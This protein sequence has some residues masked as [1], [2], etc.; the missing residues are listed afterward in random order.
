[1]SNAR[2]HKPFKEEERL[3]S[4]MAD[5]LGAFFT[6]TTPRQ[7]PAAE[8]SKEVVQQL[9]QEQVA[10]VKEQLQEQVKEQLQQIQATTPAVHVAAAKKLPKKLS[11]LVNKEG[12]YFSDQISEWLDREWKKQPRKQQKSKSWIVEQILRQHWGLP[13]LEE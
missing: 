2:S 9:L 5:G 6:N 13:P 12:L 10:Q 7:P 8:M 4:G 11:V 3:D 1:M